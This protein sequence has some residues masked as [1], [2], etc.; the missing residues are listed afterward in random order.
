MFDDVI[1]D[2]ISITYQNESILL[3]NDRNVLL[4]LLDYWLNKWISIIVVGIIELRRG[5]W[6]VG[7]LF[8]LKIGS[9][10]LS[11]CK[12]RIKLF[13]ISIRMRRQD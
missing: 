5:V 6:G 13:V 9:K 4:L 7:G 12:F 3:S 11:W 10:K 2:S 1:E 8:L